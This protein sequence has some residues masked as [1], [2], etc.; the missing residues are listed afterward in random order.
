[1][2]VLKIAEYPHTILR[3]R[4]KKVT[5]SNKKIRKFAED[6]ANTM[7]AVKGIGISAPQVG[8][9]H[10]I[11]A[12]DVGEG[13]LIVINPRLIHKEG[14]QVDIEGCL[15]LPSMVGHVKRADKV[16]LEGLDIDGEF[17]KIETEGLLARVIQHEVDHLNGILIIDR[18]IEFAVENEKNPVETMIKSNI[19]Y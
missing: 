15:S 5:K 16:V 18:A 14:E 12:V 9:L 3:R 17:I 6:L 4:A 11:I 10:Q 13:L 19:N 1:M 2:N 8:I 7:Y